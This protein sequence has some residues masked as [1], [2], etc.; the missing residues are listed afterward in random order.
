MHGFEHS[1]LQSGGGLLD[2]DQR[3][4]ATRHLGRRDDAA[5]GRELLAPCLG[6]RLLE[7]ELR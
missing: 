3:L 1:L 6:H 7:S 5:T 2:D 4:L